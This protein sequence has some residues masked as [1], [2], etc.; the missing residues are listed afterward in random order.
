MII[1]ERRAHIICDPV[2]T[3]ATKPATS[4]A[5]PT[6]ISSSNHSLT[7]PAMPPT[8]DGHHP[9]CPVEGGNG[10]AV[11]AM[12]ISLL[13]DSNSDDGQSLNRK[14]RMSFAYA[15]GQYGRRVIR[16]A[17]DKRANRYWAN[18]VTKSGG[19]GWLKSTTGGLSEAYER[20]HRR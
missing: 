18:F 20:H 6:E 2:N 5:L 15:D 1:A 3:A 7:E 17:A 16:A 12:S 4:E 19:T 9:S 8:K 10:R 11:S 13:F 14:L